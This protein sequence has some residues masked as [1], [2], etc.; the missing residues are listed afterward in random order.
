MTC[1]TAD[2][3]APGAQDAAA[4]AGVGDPDDGGGAA[5]TPGEASRPSTSAPPAAAASDASGL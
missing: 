2:P 4:G 3:L 1:L 5:D